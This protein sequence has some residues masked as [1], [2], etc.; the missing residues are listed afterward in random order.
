MES[1][2]AAALEIVLVITG[3]FL[4]SLVSLGRW[5]GESLKGNEGQI[6]GAAGALSFHREGKRVITHTGQ[7][8][9]G[10]AFYVLLIILAIAYA[11]S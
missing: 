2:F 11:A 10:A 7:L 3:R 5:R 6:H 1:L 4:V 8:F 9:L